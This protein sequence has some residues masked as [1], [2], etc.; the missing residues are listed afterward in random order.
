MFDEIS[1]NKSQIPI[2]G[3]WCLKFVIYSSCVFHLF[4]VLTIFL[5]SCAPD[6]TP[7][8]YIRIGVS[9]ATMRESVYH[10]MKKAINE[11]SK[12]FNAKIFWFSAENSE[13]KQKSDIK[14]L[15]NLKIDVLIFHSVNT[16]NSYEILKP[17]IEKE[18]PI[19][20]MDRLPEDVKVKIYVTAN[21]YKVGEIQAE[22]LASALKGKGKVVIIKG[23]AGNNVAEEIT[24]GNIDMLS[25]YPFIE[26]IGVY[27]HYRWDKK[28]AVA[29]MRRLIKNNII[30]DGIL[31]NNSSMAM[32]VLS[33]LKKNGMRIKIIAADA[34]LDACKSIISGELLADVDK[35]PYEIGL[36]S[37]KSAVNIAR[38]LPLNIDKIIKV[39][40]RSVFVKFT[41]IKLIT[42]FNIWEMKYRWP[43]LVKNIVNCKNN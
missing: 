31:S 12:K 27:S 17:V 2:F 24:K 43:D 16:K 13:K 9:V 11:N 40:N 4:L 25:R 26:I 19:V 42:K 21:S 23:E 29:T 5:L 41:P 14:Q 35:M 30:P 10:F 15:V 37:L 22:Y 33:V 34:D 32:G 1:N 3:I 39:R 28:L 38:N 36:Q 8:P 6:K 20:A 7:K 18:I